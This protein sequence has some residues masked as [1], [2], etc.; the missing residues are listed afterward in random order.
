[1]PEGGGSAKCFL[2][3]LAVDGVSLAF[4][5]CLPESRVFFL[6][7]PSFPEY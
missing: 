4:A 5:V 2:I 7:T 3:G 1:M 6:N